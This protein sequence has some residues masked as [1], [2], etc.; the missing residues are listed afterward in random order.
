MTNFTKEM[1]KFMVMVD[2]KKTLEKIVSKL[3]DIEGDA[4]FTDN[5]LSETLA[6]QRGRL[7]ARISELKSELAELR[8][9]FTSAELIAMRKEAKR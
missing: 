5:E 3:F 9:S 4:V 6:K 8:I 7:N 2:E 1:Q